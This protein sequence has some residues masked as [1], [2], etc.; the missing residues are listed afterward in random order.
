M[1]DDPTVT[2]PEELPG[3]GRGPAGQQGDAAPPV[4]G[5]Y[6]FKAAV[7]LRW[8]E[9]EGV[10]LID[11]DLGGG[12]GPY[13]P[14]SSVGV[15][16]SVFE[17]N[18]EATAWV[19]RVWGLFGEGFEGAIVDA[20]RLL[21]NDAAGLASIEAGHSFFNKSGVLAGHLALAE[22]VTRQRLGLAPRS[23]WPPWTAQELSAE[24][25]QAMRGIR[26]KVP[27]Y[28]TVAARLQAKFPGRPPTTGGSLRKMVGGYGIDWMKLKRRAKKAE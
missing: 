3:A 19:R 15:S 20:L 1:A 2:G 25:L 18:A 4:V 13:L 12:S 8:R 17:G 9:A 22:H 21:L 10:L 16:A 5:E 6:P 28:P 7:K 11:L 23:K 26:G 14:A 24:I 27:T